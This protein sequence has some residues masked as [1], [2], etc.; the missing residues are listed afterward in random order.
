M[1]QEFVSQS[2]TN[3]LRNDELYQRL[4]LNLSKMGEVELLKR[5]EDIYTSNLSFV[6]SH[7]N[8][9]YMELGIIHFILNKL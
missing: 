6:Y 2:K 9:I 3:P 5:L 7:R 4:Y 1:D 8:Q